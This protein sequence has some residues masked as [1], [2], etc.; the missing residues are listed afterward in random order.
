M[1]F[2]LP[3]VK[4]HSHYEAS[5][6]SHIKKRPDSWGGETG[7][8][9]S[10]N[11]KEGRLRFRKKQG[12]LGGRARAGEERVWGLESRFRGGKVE[13]LIWLREQIEEEDVQAGRWRWDDWE[14]AEVFPKTGRKDWGEVRTES[15]EYT[16]IGYSRKQWFRLWCCRIFK[17]TW[18]AGPSGN[19]KVG[20]SPGGDKTKQK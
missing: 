9:D 1:C 5:H 2:P 19:R 6:E 17:G 7:R 4:T 13:R 3:H 14:R 11:C 8:E 16:E 18:V 10:E 15:I 20:L 12:K